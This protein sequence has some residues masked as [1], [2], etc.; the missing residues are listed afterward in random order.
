MRHFY[1]NAK[2]SS[3]PYDHL[4]PECEAIAVVVRNFILKDF[5]MGT[6]PTAMTIGS[7]ARFGANNL[8]VDQIS[9]EEARRML[10]LEAVLD[11][12]IRQVIRPDSA[13]VNGPPTQPGPAAKKAPPD[14]RP[15]DLYVG[16]DGVFEHANASSLQSP[17]AGVPSLTVPPPVL[18]SDSSEK[19]PKKVKSEPLASAPAKTKSYPV[20]KSQQPVHRGGWCVK[21]DQLA[22]EYVPKAFVPVPVIGLKLRT[23]LPPT[24]PNRMPPP[25]LTLIPKA[26][27][28]VS[29]SSS[30]GAADPQEDFEKVFGPSV[31]NAATSNNVRHSAM[32]V[33]SVV[34]GTSTRSIVPPGNRVPFKAP[35]GPPPKIETKPEPVAFVTLPGTSQTLELPR[36]REPAKAPAQTKQEPTAF[37][38]DPGSG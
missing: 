36:A 17:T 22:Q 26:M 9:F 13:W 1:V 7:Y 16:E 23:K 28:K 6:S 19:E 35:P 5:V 2:G 29:V 15:A 27:P 14:R 12:R 37:V 31:A 24:A 10:T 38:T 21:I 30:A 20:V 3:A 11:P 8:S 4:Q 32:E 25:W 33:D 34:A 18:G